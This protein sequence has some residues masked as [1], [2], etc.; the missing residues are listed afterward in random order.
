MSTIGL[1]WAQQNKILVAMPVL[2]GLLILAAI[3]T[4]NLL[5][6]RVPVE[7]AREYARKVDENQRFEKAGKNAIGETFL[8]APSAS[9]ASSAPD[10][11]IVQTSS[12][13]LTVQDPKDSYDKIRSFV[14][15]LGGYVESSEITGEQNVNATLTIR[16]PAS[17]LE[18][19]KADLRKLALQVDSEKSNAQDVTRQ[20]VDTDARL[21]NLRAQEAQYLLIM[22]SAV[23][24]QDMLDVS[25]HLSEVRGEIEQQQAEFQTFSKQ[26]E[27]A[28]IVVSLRSQIDTAV[29]GLNWRPLY[30]LKVAARQALDGIADYASTMA[31]AILY[32]PVLFLWGVTSLF[33]AVAGWRVVRWAVRIF[34]TQSKPATV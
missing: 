28:T 9:T 22:K 2:A 30:Q 12:V 20:Y 16:V 7:K 11:K 8:A 5:R 23:K 21:R 3:C 15:A 26:I 14:E 1:S 19:A 17:R 29:F 24:V 6:T 33:A 25:E 31:S 13:E 34:F 4:P 27:M 32:L 18:D 10:R